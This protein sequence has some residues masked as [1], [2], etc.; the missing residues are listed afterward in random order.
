[1]TQI[2]DSVNSFL[3]SDFVTRTSLFRD[4]ISLRALA[5]Y[6]LRQH[7]LSNSHMDAAVSAIRRYKSTHKQQQKTQSNP[8]KTVRI[9]TKD[10]VIDCY[11]PK[12]K[13]VQE[14][15]SHFQNK[16][17]FEKGDVLRIIQAEQGIRVIFDEYN[18]PLYHSLFPKKE[19]ITERKKLAEVNLLF[20]AEAE[21]TPGIISTIS[22]SLNVGGISITE[23][24]SSAPE[25]ILIVSN[26]DVI[27]VLK[28]LEGLKR[29]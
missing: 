6:F 3:D 25:L 12:N 20:T 21:K 11:L 10:N 7:N 5:R 13:D 2:A 8:F 15:L 1:M 29:F 23:I 26:D 24:M 28:I 4:V 19:T 22:S 16:I 9:K 17:N 14:K 27:P 18:L